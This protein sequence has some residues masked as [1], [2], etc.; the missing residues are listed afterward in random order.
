MD[1]FFIW[2]VHLPLYPEIIIIKCFPTYQL[3]PHSWVSTLNNRSSAK[4][5]SCITRM[6]NLMKWFGKIGKKGIQTSLNHNTIICFSKLCVDTLRKV[7]GKMILSLE[8]CA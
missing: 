8:S 6:K 7:G 1:F 2:K 3:G 4:N 5:K